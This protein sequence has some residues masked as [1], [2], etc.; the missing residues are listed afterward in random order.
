[1]KEEEIITKVRYPEILGAFEIINSEA[2][3][4][5]SSW[6]SGRRD[7]LNKTNA[8]GSLDVITEVDLDI[9][10]LAGEVFGRIIPGTKMF[11]EENFKQDF[12]V[13]EGP[14]YIVVDPIDGTKEFI[15]GNDEWS[16]S[17]CVV[18]H[19]LPTASSIFMPDRNEVFVATKAG[20]VRLNGRPLIRKEIRVQKI[21]VSPRQIKSTNVLEKIKATG[22][23][24]IEVSAFTPKICAILRGDVAAAAYFKQ[25]GQ[26][27]SLWDYAAS[28]L[29]IEE[30]GGQITSLTGD[31]L[32]FMGCNVI[33]TEGWLATSCH[34]E[35]AELLPKLKGAVCV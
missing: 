20:G 21:A 31:K 25:T 19:G 13:T 17:I 34:E 22:Y 2:V 1:M 24:P 9:E 15:K 8:N 14:L 29:T 5:V 26:S 10:R 18:E 16:I 7:V 27:A 12:S 23:E 28:I 3:K 32:P 35:H 30:F 4:I 11:G 33:H 6:R